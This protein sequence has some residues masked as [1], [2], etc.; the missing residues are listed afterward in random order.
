M[1]LQFI[2]FV[3]AKTDMYSNTWLNCSEIQVINIYEPPAPQLY[4]EHRIL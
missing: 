4:K 3:T 1:V 2:Q